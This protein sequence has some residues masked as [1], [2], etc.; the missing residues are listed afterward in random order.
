ML[1]FNGTSELL[2][3]LI[4]FDQSCNITTMLKF[5]ILLIYVQVP[6]TNIIKPLIFRSQ[7]QFSKWLP[8]K[9]ENLLQ[10]NQTKY[11]EFF[12]KLPCLYTSPLILAQNQYV[13]INTSA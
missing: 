2:L 13:L 11:R 3:K 1:K 10:A 12:M 8:W 5:L 9:P 4:S 7:N 6:T